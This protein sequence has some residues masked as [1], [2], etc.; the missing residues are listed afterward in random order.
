MVYCPTLITVTYVYYDMAASASALLEV[1][2]TL[3]PENAGAHILQHSLVPVLRHLDGTPARAVI[4]FVA[5]GI[6][7]YSC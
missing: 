2:D 1:I 5:V 7:V 3:D 6:P 4:I